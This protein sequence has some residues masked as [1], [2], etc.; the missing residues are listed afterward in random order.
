LQNQIEAKDKCD[1]YAKSHQFR[2]LDHLLEYLAFEVP[3]AALVIIDEI[4][5]NLE[6]ILG[7]RFQFG[8]EVMELRR[9]ENTSKERVYRFEPFLAGLG[10][11][12]S[13]VDDEEAMDTVVVP[14][15]SE[16]FEDVFLRED[17]WYSIRIHGTMRP[18]IKYIAGYQVQPVS[19]ITH[20][21][22]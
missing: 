1:E 4:P 20:I 5:D 7:E 13:A 8:V 6:T 17:R 12:V 22:R 14:A 10:E 18:Q 2:N 11:D 21:A 9:Y 3:F 19:A 16:G 15:R